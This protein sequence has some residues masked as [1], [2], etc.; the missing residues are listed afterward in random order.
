MCSPGSKISKLLIAALDDPKISGTLTLTITVFFIFSNSLTTTLLVVVSAVFS[1]H[2][3]NVVPLPGFFPSAVKDPKISGAVTVSIMVSLTLTTSLT[4]T[5][6]AT[7]NVVLWFL[8]L[9]ILN[10]KVI[11]ECNLLKLFILVLDDRK[12]SGAL[13]LTITVFFFMSNTI[14]TTFLVTA[15][16]VFSLHWFDIVTLTQFFPLWLK[17][18]KISGVLMVT[19]AVLLT[20]S[21][22]LIT[23][24]SVAAIVILWSNWLKIINLTYVFTSERNFSGLIFAALRDPKISGVLMPTITVFFFMSDI[25]VIT[26]SV[27]VFVIFSLHQF[28]IITLTHIFDLGLNNPKISGVLMV[29]ITVLLTL[30]NSLTTTFSVAVIVT[31]WLLAEHR[32]TD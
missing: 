5:V 30:S 7:V 10:L 2:W 15:F 19:I 27:L 22:S 32:C 1:L 16:T 12:L 25:V 3:L 23:A 8:W 4:T 11:F 24:L 17:N 21:T 13:T 20:M 9:K 29:T 18:P 26:L 31:L 6:L 14:L 28:D